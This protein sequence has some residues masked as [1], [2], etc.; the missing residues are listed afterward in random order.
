MSDNVE[1]EIN[2]KWTGC[3]IFSLVVTIIAMAIFTYST[4]SYLFMTIVICNS[5]EGCKN[6]VW[7]T[8]IFSALLLTS[9]ICCCVAIIKNSREKVKKINNYIHQ[10]IICHE[11]DPR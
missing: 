8:L 11:Q 7:I 9:T 1:Y 4:I 6:W 5:A 10:G 2:Y 3:S